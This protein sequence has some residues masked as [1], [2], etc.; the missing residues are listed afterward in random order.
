MMASFEERF[1]S[2]LWVSV[3]IATYNRP[4]LLRRLL[5]QLDLQTLDPS[6]YEVIAV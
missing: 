1:G 2:G 3:V 4:E 5:E 6:R